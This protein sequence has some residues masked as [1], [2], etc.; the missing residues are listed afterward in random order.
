MRTAARISVGMASLINTLGVELE[1]KIGQASQIAAGTGEAGH[2]PKVDRIDHAGHHN[3]NGRGGVL[4]RLCA[5]RTMGYEHIDVE[6]HQLGCELGEAVVPALSPPIVDDNV[7]PL[8]V[9]ELAK[10]H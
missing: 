3:W 7:L 6:L 1:D 2:E 9:S 5:G 4:G 8:I 10:S